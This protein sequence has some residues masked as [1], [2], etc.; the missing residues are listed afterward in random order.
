MNEVPEGKCGYTWGEDYGAGDQLNHQS[1]CWRDTYQDS[2]LCVWHADP[3]EVGEKAV[4]A[5][6]QS[7]VDAEIREQTQ[8]GGELLDGAV[9]TGI[10]FDPSFAL[11]EYYLRD[12]DLSETILYNADF[13][14]ANLSK[15]NFTD[16]VLGR[17][18]FTNA[19]LS[20]ANLTGTNLLGADLTDANF[21]DADLTD[22]N[23][24]EAD[25]TDSSLLSADLTGANFALADLTDADLCGAN[26]TGA[27][28]VNT[29]LTDADLFGT[30]FTSLNLEGANLTGAN[31]Y[32]INLSNAH[33]A[34]ADL[35]DADLQSADLTD[36]DLR[37][38]DLTDANLKNTELTDSDL[39]DATLRWTSLKDATAIRTNFTDADLL[40]ANLEGASLKDSQFDGTNL[41]GTRFYDTKPQGMSINDQTVFSDQTVYEREADP[42]DPWHLLDGESTIPTSLRDKFALA[43]RSGQILQSRYHSADASPPTESIAK[44][45]QAIRRFRRH[46]NLGT[47][48]RREV[49][50]RLKKATSVYRIRQRL[51]RENSRPRDVAQP[52]VR[53][54]HSRRKRAFVTVSYWEWFKHSTYRWVMLYGE[55]PARVVGTSIVVVAVFAAIYSVVGGIVIGG[56]TPDLIGYIYFSAVTFSTLGYGGI[57]P[58]TTTT[59]LLAS[60]QSLIGGILIALLV[61]V[62]GRRALR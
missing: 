58:T 57:E 55:S 4:E 62:F 9:L 56:E 14:D 34:D 61:A 8:P 23:L 27:N 33:L 53:E 3:D 60:V 50:D 21:F 45:R 30:D 29:N 24:L 44:V 5:L 54:Q 13:A 15:A 59:Q 51:Q 10:E 48:D 35:T 43:V 19:V 25:L 2:D 49:G 32:Q 20:R 41:T 31:L 11:E 46:R 52:Y 12:A 42:C 17:T 7:L 38:T 28:F 1:C 39:T 22:A 6:R 26:L 18:D 36:A 37:V 40:G 47:E 16:A